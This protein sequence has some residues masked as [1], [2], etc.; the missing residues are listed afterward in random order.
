[1]PQNQKKNEAINVNQS[2]SRLLYN[3]KLFSSMDVE[4]I[5]AIYNAQS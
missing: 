4:K 5:K 1:M 2:E 3:L